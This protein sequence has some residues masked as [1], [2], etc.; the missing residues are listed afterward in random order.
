MTIECD[1]LV[2]GGG[3]AGIVASLSLAKK[4]IDAILLEKRAE[5]GA[6]TNTKIDIT[7]QEGL[8][9]MNRELEQQNL[10][11]RRRG[12]GTFGER[13]APVPKTPIDKM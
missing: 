4:N 3:P 10:L 7:P 1:V 6:H 5:V 8:E 9:E 2:V 13:S 11:V 12:S